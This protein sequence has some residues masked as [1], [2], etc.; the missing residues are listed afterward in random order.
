MTYNY[1][2]ET[3]QTASQSP[4]LSG[5]GIS[6]AS[7]AV[8]GTSAFGSVTVGSSLNQVFTVTNSGQTAATSIALTS[9]Q[10]GF[11]FGGGTCST[12]LGASSSCTV[13]VTFT[14]SSTTSFSSS[15]SLTYNNGVA[16]G[17]TAKSEPRLNRNGNQPG[18]ARI[19]G[20]LRLWF[21]HGWKFTQPDFHSD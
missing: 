1:G 6:P 3:G 14:P 13:I 20:H 19:L 7:L 15:L 9:L 5:T 18:I 2:V 11:T 8:S 17:R 10:T 21:S 16:S 4:N 12:S